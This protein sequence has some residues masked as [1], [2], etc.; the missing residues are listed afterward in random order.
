MRDYIER[1]LELPWFTKSKE[2]RNLNR[3]AAQLD[4]DHYG[5]EKVKERVIEFLAVR[6][7]A[8][9][10]DAPI[11]CLV[12]PPGV[13]KTSI[14][15]SVAKA[16]DRKYVRMSLGGVRDEAEI[17]GHRKTYVGAMP[18]RILDAMR[19][20]ATMNPL[21]LLD[22]IDKLGSDFRGNPAAAL[23]EVLDEEQNCAFRDHYLE[24]P[25]DLSD[26]LFICTANALEGIPQPL[27]DRLEIIEIFSYTQDEKQHI[28]EDF[29]LP[30]QLKK[31][32]L[33]KAQLRCPPAVIT[34]II[35]FYTREAGVRQLERLIASLCR[36]TVKLLITEAQKS[37]RVNSKN[38]SSFLGKRKYRTQPANTAMEVG[39]CQGLAWTASGGDTLS[40]EVNTMRGA[41]KFKL[42]GNVGKVMEESAQAAVSYIRSHSDQLSIHRNFYKDTDIH[43]HIP[44][45]ATPKDGPSAGITMATALASALTGTPVNHK[46]A[47]TGE[48]TIRGRVLPI[49]GLKEKILA[50]KNAG[51]QTVL[52]P[53]ENE[54]DLSEISADIKEG[55][56]FVLVKTMEEVLT[57]ALAPSAARAGDPL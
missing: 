52:L 51:I 43:I 42:T 41:G 49:G 2:N 24:L 20:A 23:L 56:D 46:I 1:V 40:I 15:R 45:G 36:K 6:Q 38:L 34:D 22:E 25:Y 7:N 13:G 37:V 31:H 26:V 48:I 55:L 35:Q 12:G 29:L 3:A 5:L 16:L 28:A 18:G 30:K 14:A 54:S 19:Q 53:L 47:M 11:L 32:G 17:R 8:A 44:E 21:I 50:A 27:I 4:K 9:S 57:R 39:I 10:L 33:R